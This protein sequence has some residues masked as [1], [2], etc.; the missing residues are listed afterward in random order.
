[1]SDYI[2]SGKSKPNFKVTVWRGDKNK[3]YEE[4]P[5]ILQDIT[6]IEIVRRWDMA[7]D[8]LNIEISNVN[9]FYSPDYSNKKIF[10]NAYS[11]PMS[12]YKGVIKAF[13]KIT[14][15]LGYG[16]EL[17]R[18]FTGQIQSIS[19]SEDGVTINFNALNEYRK[20]L[21]PIDPIDKRVLKYEGKVPAGD[22]I[23]DLAARA[24]IHYTVFENEEIGEDKEVFTIENAKFDLGTNYSDA[25]KEIVSLM[26]HRVVC[27]RD[28][29]LKVIKKEIYSQKDFHNWEFDD[30][31]NILQ[32]EYTIDPA[33][34]RNRAIII[35]KNGWQAFEDKFLIDYC[36]GEIIPFAVKAEWAET[37]EQKWAVADDFFLQMRRK[38]RRISVT[39]MGNPAMDAGDLVKMKMMTSTANDKY[40]ITGITSSF[41]TSGYTEEVEVEYIGV[42]NGH[43]CEK[44]EGKYEQSEDDIVSEPIES[45][46]GLT[47]RDKILREAEG[48]LGIYYQWGG[49]YPE[50]G[51]YGLDCSHFTYRVLNNFGLMKN[52]MIA[53]GQKNWCKP[54]TRE[55]L[56]PGD[57]IFYDWG[58]DGKV[59]H[60]TM[61]IGN[62][63]QIES[64]GGGPSTT[65]ISKAK[66]QNAKVKKSAISR[67]GKIYYGRPPGL[68]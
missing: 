19:I 15:D 28:G 8:E 26:N 45:I 46:A 25:L 36:N 9:G 2:Q 22:I 35:S 50:K 32:G 18:I 40:M 51:W 41:N 52:Y 62:G 4:F 23:N 17:I 31:I 7:A 43:L 30:Y 14:C 13:N 60:V 5:F 59:D 47:L 55:E 11:L 68:E 56:K 21:K 6:K 16:D 39:V 1:M 49:R 48:Y 10:T 3:Y 27:S 24:S 37:E 61:Y 67:G 34:L 58:R 53:N 54:I 12:G 42:I 64:G 33:V 57:L 38:L 65:T 44:A 63:M 20:L 66:S 29:I